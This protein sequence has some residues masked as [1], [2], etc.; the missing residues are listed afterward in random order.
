MKYNLPVFE[1]QLF[2]INGVHSGLN[3]RLFYRRLLLDF[4]L[5]DQMRVK[6][7]FQL[8]APSLNEHSTKVV[9]PNAWFALMN[10]AARESIEFSRLSPKTNT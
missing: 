5:W 1:I 6:K 7:R 4:W 9:F 10:P 8:K 2:G 3:N